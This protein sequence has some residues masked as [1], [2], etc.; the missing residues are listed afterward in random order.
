MISIG[1]GIVVLAL[2]LPAPS[3]AAD[4]PEVGFRHMVI[5]RDAPRYPE[6]KGVGD[7]DGDG[8]V[9]V[10][11]GSDYAQ[12]LVWYRYPNWTKHRIADGSFSTDMQVGD[13]DHDGDLDVIIPRIDTGLVWYE[14]PRP[15]GKP[16][17]TPWKMRKIDNEGGHDVEVGDID[18]DGR[19]DV[20]VREGQ[21]RVFL[22]E[23]PGTWRKIAVQTGG[24]GGTALGDLDGDG[25]L[26]IAQNGYWLETPSDKSRSWTR[27]EII[28][29]WPDDVGVHIVDLNKDGRQDVLIAPAESDGRLAWYEAADPKRGPWTEHVIAADVAYIHTF[30]TAD[31]E[32]DGDLDV[33][34]AE[35]EQSPRR[36]VSVYLNE[37]KALAWHQQVLSRTGAHNLR[38]ADIGN[39][40]DIDIVGANFGH[41]G[42]ATPI[43]LW[44]NLWHA[45]APSL[46]LDRWERHV[47]DSRKPWGSAF[48]LAGDLDGDGL[49][50]IVTGGWW[51]RNPGRPGGAWERRAL[52]EPLRDAAAIAD[53]DGDGDWDVLGTQGK[54]P[55]P[56]PR[57]AW[58]RNDGQ[59]RLIVLTNI[60]PG[61]GDFLQGCTAFSPAFRRLDVAL[62]WHEG[63]RGVQVLTVPGN[64]SAE[65]WPWRKISDVSQDEQLSA[66]HI[67]GDLEVDL[68]L[69]T[70]WLRRSGD[71][72]A[73]QVLNPTSGD[74][75]RNRLADING[76]GRLDSVVG[77]EAIN[78]P[79]KL[80]W[81]EQPRSATDTWTEHV[82][83]TVVGPMSLDVADID[84]DGDIDVVVGEHNYQDPATAKL[85]VFENRDGHGGRWEDHVISKGDEH[86][87]GAVLA[88]IDNDGDLDVLSIGWQHPRVLLYEN[89]AIP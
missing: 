1:S 8:F 64:P 80:A 39:D 61:Q 68:L 69:G 10:L 22:Q 57:F 7:L 11:V 17:T 72:W 34:T 71:H 18:G 21:S 77:F 30:K 49:G 14:N 42:G 55:D 87:D 15:N 44:E 26:D 43:E 76:D 73:L 29:G 3:G 65:T 48:V 27:H 35:L 79:G 20:V 23:Q 37:G 66:G 78:V 88:D 36:R 89:Q 67:D 45:P 2:L 54:T 19:L 28:A 24:R 56:D 63:G 13:V 50:D 83:A 5:D 58:A 12:G 25:D 38:V 84:R 40:G 33:V 6:C 41:N 52:G 32:G 47:V 53:F 74:P 16:A 62:S 4:P 46:P 60:T 70:K 75:D 82:I 81:Y 86:H 51:Y 9:D 31:V 59:G 85:L